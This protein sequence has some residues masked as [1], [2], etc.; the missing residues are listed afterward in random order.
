LILPEGLVYRSDFVTVDEER[1]LLDQLDAMEF[2]EIVMRGQTAR[3]VTRHFGLDYDY[4]TFKVTPTEPL[5]QELEWLRSRAAELVGTQAGALAEILITRYPPGAP[6]GWHRDA[7]SFDKVI[8]IS[9][10]A[11]AR[12]RFQRGKAAE[13]EVAE[14][15]LEPRSAYV[16][17]GPARTQWQHSIPPVKELRYSVTFRTLRARGGPRSTRSRR[18]AA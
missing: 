6:I 16:L 8:G 1:E 18:T 15:V 2:R 10:G 12:M 14:L 11:A 9:L 17:D 13:R 4:E 7:P 3:R 5:P